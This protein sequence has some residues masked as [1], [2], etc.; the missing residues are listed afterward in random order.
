M[1]RV[2]VIGMGNMGSQHL[3]V[4]GDLSAKCE[5]VGVAEKDE[6][7]WESRKKSTGGEFFSD[8]HEMLTNSKPDA[9]SIALPNALHCS[10]AIDCLKAG[11]DVLVE[12]PIAL[13]LNDA[14]RMIDV[15]RHEERVLMVGHVERFNPAVQFI[16]K[17]VN[18]GKLGE[19]YY[20]S[21]RR[22]GFYPSRLDGAGRF[23]VSLDLAIHDVDVMRFIMGQRPRVIHTDRMKRRSRREDYVCMTL[24]FGKSIGILEASWLSPY[25]I[26]QLI[27]NGAE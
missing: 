1:I 21:S 6:L 18:D 11:V 7:R 14:K 22:L 3:R 26:R 16:R 12:K 8:Y 10:A 23:G 17:Y 24:R 9:V 27:V 19:L 25:K 5:V 20:L 15:A 2:G 4:Y 13:S